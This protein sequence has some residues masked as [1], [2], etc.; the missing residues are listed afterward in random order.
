MTSNHLFRTE[1]NWLR[2]SIRKLAEDMPSLRNKLETLAS[3][4]DKL[5]DSSVGD[6]S[7]F[8]EMIFELQAELNALRDENQAQRAQ[9]EEQRAQIEELREQVAELQEKNQAFHVAALRRQIAIN[10]EYEIK[11]DYLLLCTSANVADLKYTYSAKAGQF[12]PH[13]VTKLSIGK[14]KDR[15][16]RTC[17]PSELDTVHKNWFDGDDQKWDIFRDAMTALKRFSHESA[18][19]TALNGTPIDV[20]SARAL[21]VDTDFEEPEQRVVALEFVE[22]LQDIRVR[23][24]EPV[25]LYR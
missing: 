5:D 11:M 3:R 14:A 13:E 9:I 10:I 22:K 16:A 19:P 20:E 17:S 4:V 15:A 25:Y 21:V 6:Y 24:N 23:N 18:H 8:V 7:I 1:R 12:K 2:T